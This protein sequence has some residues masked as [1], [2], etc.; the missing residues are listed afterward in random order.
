MST[1]V[2]VIHF[3]Q[4][5]AAALRQ[6]LDLVGGIEP[7]NTPSREVTIKVGIFDPRMHHHTAVELVDAITKAFDRAPHI[8][9]AES[10]NYCGPAMERLERFRPV[11]SERVSPYSLSGDP[12]ARIMTIAGEVMGLSP[13]LFKP[14]VFV[15]TH[16]LRT[17]NKGSVLKNLF[18]CTPMVK[19]SPFHKNEVFGPLLCDLFQ[20]SGGIDLAVLD[21]RTLTHGASG[22]QIPMNLLVVGRDAVAVET[23]GA[24]LAGLKPEKMDVIQAFVERGLGEGNLNNIEILGVARDQ[25]ARLIKEKRKELN[26]RIAAKPRQPGISDTIDCLTGEGWLDVGRTAEQ[27]AAELQGRGVSNANKAMVDTTLKRR[28]G[29]TLLRFKEDGKWIYRK[30]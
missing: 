13:V 10:D 14:N 18:G 4:N 3:E 7:I 6:A 23:V 30:G 27:V 2:A 25:L 26:A 17:F 1:P 16:V 21:G 22:I 20:A 15:S 12:D 24:W 11:F 5:D 19:K 9:L 8:Y 29:K 28:V